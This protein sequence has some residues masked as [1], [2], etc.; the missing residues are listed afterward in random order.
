MVNDKKNNNTSTSQTKKDGKGPHRH[1]QNWNP[2]EQ[3]KEGVP[4]LHYGTMNN[5]HKFKEALAEWAI[6]EY[7]HLGKLI[8]QGT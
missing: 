4:A 1:L 6:K 5:F 3:K 7:G 2:V 8:E